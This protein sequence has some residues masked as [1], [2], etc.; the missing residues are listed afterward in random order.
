MVGQPARL[1]S[2]IHGLDLV[3]GGGFIEGASYIIQGPP[4]AGKTILSNQIAFGQIAAGRR[5]LYVTLLAETHDRLFQSLATL[6]FFDIAQLGDNIKYVSVFQ[7]LRDEGLNAVVKVIR[8]ETQRQ[9][10]GLLIFD[11]LLNARD[12]A[13]TDFDVKTFIAEI[14]SQAA[15]VGCTVLFLTSTHGHDISPEHTMV[16]GVIDLSEEVSGVR[17]YRRLQIRKSRGSASLN[18]YHQFE[19][20]SAGIAVF[21][22]LERHLPVPSAEDGP[23]PGRLS[24][25]VAGLDEAIGGGLPCG[26]ISIIAGAPGSGKTSLGLSFLRESSA[27]Q[28][29]LLFGF[30]ESPSR[31]LLKGDALGLGITRSVESNAV[32]LLWNPLT[33][34]ILDKLAY[35]LLEAVHRRKVKRLVID[36]LS[37]FE[38]AAIQSSRLLE[39]FVALTNELRSLDVTTIM[40]W[41]VQG[42]PGE[43]ESVNLPYISGI[44]DNL[45]MVHQVQRGT[46]L[47]RVLSIVK[48]RDNIYPHKP[49]EVRFMADGLGISDPARAE[50]ADLPHDAPRHG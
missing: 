24:T 42:I 11:G 48:I 50:G 38:R 28:P 20:T 15:F 12:R 18:G 32:E 30:Y 2:G 4:G 26:S 33:E 9:G 19:I 45:L 3:L 14:Q 37:G 31:L 25:G 1:A 44:L 29:G 21:P 49:Y 43:K 23:D 46:T 27:E 8:E 35:Q 39:F 13:E 47:M 36:G 17:S 34:N 10:A 40:T 22:R 16:D 41:E 5:I 7:P 6:S